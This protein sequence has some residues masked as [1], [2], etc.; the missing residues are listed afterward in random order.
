MKILPKKEKT[1]FRGEIP[2]NPLSRKAATRSASA[3]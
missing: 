2:S 3:Q 1:K